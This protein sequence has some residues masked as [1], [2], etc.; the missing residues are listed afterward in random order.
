GHKLVL[1]EK[2]APVMAAAAEKPGTAE[3]L[4]QV[5]AQC[6]EDNTGCVLAPPELLLADA[7]TG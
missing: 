7:E 1:Q 4:F 6:Q 3:A 5:S 2:S